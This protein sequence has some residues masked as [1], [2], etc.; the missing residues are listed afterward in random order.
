MVVLNSKTVLLHSSRGIEA[1]GSGSAGRPLIGSL[2]R[3]PSDAVV[4]AIQQGIADLGFG[5]LRPAYFSI[6]INLDHDRGSRIS[7]LADAG[8]VTKQTMGHL[9]GY[10]ER[11]GYVDVMPD[12]ADARAKLVRFTERGWRVHEAANELVERLEDAWRVALGVERFETLID[13]L[14]ELGRVASQDRGQRP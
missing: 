2:L 3:G 1:M 6:I 13:L 7:D 5:D 12:P 4:R 10:L 11:R 14:S 9:V 8:R